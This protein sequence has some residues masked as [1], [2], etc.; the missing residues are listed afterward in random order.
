MLIGGVVTEAALPAMSVA[1]ALIFCADPSVETV[2]G[3]GQIAMPDK[4]S[5]QKKL[6]ITSVLFHPAALGAGAGLALITGGVPSRLTVADALAVFPAWSVAL[7]VMIWA[8][9]SVFTG[10]GGGQDTMSETLG[11]QTKPTVTSVLFQSAALGVG[12]TFAV[13]E[14]VVFS[15]FSGTATEVLFPARSLTEAVICSAFPSVLTT[16]GDG[17]LP[18]AMPDKLSEQT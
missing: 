1:W 13:I 12:L 11:V 3:E 18:S 9:P 6:T 7:P 4:L 14:G 16:C 15:I 17:Q 2:T 5:E 8:L 10:T